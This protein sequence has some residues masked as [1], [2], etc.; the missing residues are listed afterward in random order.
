MNIKKVEAQ[1]QILKNFIKAKGL[2]KELKTN[3]EK[4]NNKNIDKFINKDLKLT[5]IYIIVSFGI[6]FIIK[7]LNLDLFLNKFF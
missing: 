6:I 2:D 3:T 1:N 7:Y 4:I 5:I